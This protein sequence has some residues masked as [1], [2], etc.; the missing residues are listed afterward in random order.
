MTEQT[1]DQQYTHARA[2]MEG[3]DWKLRAEIADLEAQT[4]AQARTIAEQAQVISEQKL[5]ISG[6]K[7]EQ[8]QIVEFLKA[9]AAE[10]AELKAA[11][12][13]I[14]KTAVM[15]GRPESAWE[16]WRICAGTANKALGR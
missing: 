6:Y 5:D 13:K 14:S 12:D 3:G 16:Q 4:I 15:L 7:A 9:N 1:F 11:L 8:I 2:Q 10:I